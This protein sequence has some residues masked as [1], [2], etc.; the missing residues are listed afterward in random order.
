MKLS[1][2]SKEGLLI[3]AFGFVAVAGIGAEIIRSQPQPDAALKVAL[4]EQYDGRASFPDAPPA[5]VTGVT[6][7]FSSLHS[8]V[9]TE[10]NIQVPCNFF[11]NGKKADANADGLAAA[12]RMALSPEAHA[13]AADIFS[14]AQYG[15]A[16]GPTLAKK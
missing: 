4:I 3:A 12:Y 9:L 10:R 2:Q 7:Q 16:C 14:Q 15:Q 6:L 13:E 5:D 1:K 8:G 11:L